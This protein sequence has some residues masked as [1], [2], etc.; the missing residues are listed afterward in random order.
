MRLGLLT[1]MRDDID[2][3]MRPPPDALLLLNGL[4]GR[5]TDM[6][7]RHLFSS[8]VLFYAAL[9]AM[10]PPPPLEHAIFMR[11]AARD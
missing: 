8:A 6:R 10:S 5:P 11:Y 9:R 2:L 7:F 3:K 1:A 4:A